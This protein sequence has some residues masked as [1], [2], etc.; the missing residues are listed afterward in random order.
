MQHLHL[1]KEK[2]KE[3]GVGVRKDQEVEATPLLL[4]DEATAL[5]RDPT[6]ENDRKR[7]VGISKTE[8]AALETNVLIS[9]ET[10]LLLLLLR[11]GI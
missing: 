8:S 7:S 9:T 6:A 11:K 5:G 3:V 2:G 4:K 1:A 10:L